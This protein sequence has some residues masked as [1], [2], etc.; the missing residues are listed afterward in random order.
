MGST[1]ALLLIGVLLT[2]LLTASFDAAQLPVA[3]STE[4]VPWIERRV[5]AGFAHGG[6]ARLSATYRMD[7]QVLL[8]M[9]VTSMPIWSRRD[10]GIVQ[11]GVVDST[12]DAHRRMR[13][14]EFFLRSFPDRARGV[15]RVGM[16][17]EAHEYVD[18]E[19]V[20]AAYFGAMS[21]APDATLDQIKASLD[22]RSSRATY[23]LI[24][25]LATA[26]TEQS[27]LY[28]I[29]GSAAPDTIDAL[30]SEVRLALAG[31]PRKS[32]GLQS[33][34]RSNPARSFLGAVH[35]SL[36][37]V[38]TLP[39]PPSRRSLPRRTTFIYNATLRVLEVTGI[40]RDT[41]AG[42]LYSGRGLAH[43]ST[44]YRLDYKLSRVGGAPSAE[45]TMWA[46]LA[47]AADRAS[48]QIAPLGFAVTPRPYL[49]LSFERVR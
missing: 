41:K 45:F 7:A 21:V 6:A 19:I 35:A 14:F 22:K 3:V 10:V 24:D 1:R 29:D 13:T 12:V 9:L 49:R 2:G 4:R 39:L 5:P 28:R 36:L 31:K 17:R 8:P 40:T 32:D 11:F 30:Y 37:D 25:G 16:L 42:Q 18:G 26:A 34:S 47:L 38:A 43:A 46:D 27:A 48:A 23:E 20:A 33:V 44:V 15:N